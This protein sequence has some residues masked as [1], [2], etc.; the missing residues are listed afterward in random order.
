MT[1]AHFGTRHAPLTARLSSIDTLRGIVM[2]L[3]ALDHVRDFFGVP[4]LSPTNLAQTTTPLFFSEWIS[5][6]R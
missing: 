1:T 6:V 4:G 2:I 5:R 3:M